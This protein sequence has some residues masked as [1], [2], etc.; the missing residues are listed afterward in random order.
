MA[1]GILRV[2]VT[3]LA[4]LVCRNGVLLGLVVLAVRVMMCGL[5][6]MVCGRVVPRRRLV[7]M[8]HRGVFLICHG[9]ALLTVVG[10]EPV[11]DR[12]QVAQAKC[13]PT[14]RIAIDSHCRIS[15]RRRHS[16]DKC[17]PAGTF[18]CSGCGF[19]EWYAQ[20]EFTAK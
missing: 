3:L 6:V 16:C 14:I 13:M 18:R 11:N 2:F 5:E 1:V 12:R 10:K 4:V 9:N 19:L 20:P 7:M 17:I 15:N 8:V